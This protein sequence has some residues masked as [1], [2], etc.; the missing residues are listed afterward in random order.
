[1]KQSEVVL[2]FLSKEAGQSTSLMSTGGVLYSGTEEIARW[3]SKEVVVTR[4]WEPTVVKHCDLVSQ[5]AE[6]MN[7][8]VVMK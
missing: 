2:A 7:I 4:V 5:L 3:E 8:K 1:M 6:S